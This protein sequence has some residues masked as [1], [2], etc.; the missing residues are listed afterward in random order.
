PRL[1]SDAGVQAAVAAAVAIFTANPQLIENPG[2]PLRQIFIARDGGM[3]ILQQ[4]MIGQPPGRRRLLEAAPLSR[5]DLARRHRVSRTHISRL[6]GDAQAAGALRL[7]PPDR[8]VFSRAFSDE[9]EAYYAG[10]VQL[11][12]LVAA[13]LAAAPG[14]S[15]A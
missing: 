9:A 13:T 3:R 15:A 1:Q 14:L 5:A 6:L 11:V 7:E 12:R 2:G 10:L 4:L 8:I